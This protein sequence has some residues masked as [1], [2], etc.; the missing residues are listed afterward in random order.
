MTDKEKIALIEETLDLDEGTLTPDTVLDDV[1]EYDSMAK[2]SLIVLFDEE[3][4]KKLTGDEVKSFKT[5]ADI[6][7]ATE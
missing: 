4:G 2:L 6:L 7:A 1:D 5:V 3:F